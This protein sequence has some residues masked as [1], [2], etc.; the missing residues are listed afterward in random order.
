MGD[1]VKRLLTGGPDVEGL[2]GGGFMKEK[3]HSAGLEGF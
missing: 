2:R 1:V 3:F